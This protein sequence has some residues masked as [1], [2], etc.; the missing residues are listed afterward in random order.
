MTKLGSRTV[1]YICQKVTKMGSVIDHRIYYNG[2]G[3]L[4]GQRLISS[5]NYPKYRPFCTKNISDY[6]RLFY[7]SILKNFEDRL[8]IRDVESVSR[9]KTANV[10]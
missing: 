2:I 1:D 8:S 10:N 6:I 5:K 4:R 3:A 7:L 9:V